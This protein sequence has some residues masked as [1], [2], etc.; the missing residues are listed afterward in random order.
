MAITIPT[1]DAPRVDSR[2]LATP[3]E[4]TNNTANEQGAALA[5][6][7]LKTASGV[8]QDVATVM[9]KAKEQ[10]DRLA[11]QEALNKQKAF[12]NAGLE[13]VRRAEGRNAAGAA[14]KYY[15]EAD[16]AAKELYAGLANDEQRLLFT[17]QADEELTQSQKVSEAHVGQQIE[18]ARDNEFKIA[19]EQS[20]RSAARDGADLPDVMVREVGSVEQRTLQY[21]KDRGLD[22]TAARSMADAEVGKLYLAQT[23]VLMSRGRYKEAEGVLAAHGDKMGE[24]A[25]AL[26][27]R[28]TQLTLEAR[29]DTQAQDILGRHRNGDGTYDLNAALAEADAK[30]EAGPERES[31]RKALVER[32]QLAAAGR[33]AEESQNWDTGL[34]AYMSLS[35]NPASRSVYLMKKTHPDAWERLTPD[36]RR[37]LEQ[38]QDADR[39]AA[40]ADRNGPLDELQLY[41]LHQLKNEIADKPEY[42]ATAPDDELFRRKEFTGLPEHYRLQLLDMVTRSKQDR[43]NPGAA[44]KTHERIIKDRL[45]QPGQPLAGT[46]GKKWEDW[47]EQ[48][49]QAA[50]VIG[51]EVAA[52]VVAWQR[53]DANKG[54]RIPDQ[55]VQGFVDD[56]TRTGTIKSGH[57]YRRDAKNVPIAKARE[58]AAK[59]A[60]QAPASF[61]PNVHEDE[62][63][64]GREVLRRR[65]W[66]PEEIDKDP[67]AII[68]A[69]RELRSVKAGPNAQERK[70][71]EAWL[72]SNGKAVLPESVQAKFEWD[73]LQYVR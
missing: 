17:P 19:N 52:R 47:T 57:W 5:A 49:Q 39:R 53:D 45:Q 15:E 41:H 20:L 67:Q 22:D 14:K 56:A 65:G 54:K 23:R 55:V 8:A 32:A 36:Q 13:A 26:R 58:M 69:A 50:V 31:T 4:S 16:K 30:Y 25:N 28:V 46:A 60:I 38:M 42:F 37:A 29:G 43:N 62:G 33:R 27:A 18:F 2:G 34:G 11:V 73:R 63:T 10:A 68:D 44:L 35:P 51:D 7:A 66:Q 48:Q 1:L 3:Y 24:E 70:E 64:L 71:I 40:K 61:A 9:Q 12:N 6:Q 21:A 59:G 72:R